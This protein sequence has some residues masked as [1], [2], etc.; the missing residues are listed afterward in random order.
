MTFTKPR[1]VP[2]L[3]KAIVFLTL[4]FSTV[5]PAAFAQI[6]IFEP[7]AGQQM[8]AGQSFD[9]KWNVVNPAALVKINLID[10]P[11]WQA[12]S[13]GMLTNE[14]NDGIANFTLPS[15]LPDGEYQIYV[16]TNL[17]GVKDW[18]YSGIFDV[19]TPTSSDCELN[20]LPTC[21]EVGQKLKFNMRTGKNN[22]QPGQTD[23]LWTLNGGP[24]YLTTLSAW[25]SNMRSWVAP[26][27]PASNT[28]NG[29]TY[30]YKAQVN[31]AEDPYFYDNLKLKLSIGGDNQVAAVRVNGIDVNG[32]G[33]G[34]TDF[35]SN[36]FE[37]LT[38][39]AQADGGPFTQGCNDIEIDVYN[40]GNTYTGMSVRGT[41]AAECT[42]CTT[43]KPDFSLDK[44]SSKKKMKSRR[45]ERKDQRRKSRRSGRGEQR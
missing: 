21:S 38:V 16:E 24:S 23:P 8:T 44:K 9:V 45:S 10:V 32:P 4:I 33:S 13:G 37:T 41:L 39:N 11:A 31:I 7:Q 2:N 22:A 14:P 25:S 19:S 17:N 43:P 1:R 26:Q 18:K 3:R 27:D 34:N 6:T 36:N 28:H 12:L 42:K 30:V 40:N 20:S 35:K 29:G 5:S 15:T